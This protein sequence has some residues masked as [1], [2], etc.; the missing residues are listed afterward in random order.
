MKNINEMFNVNLAPT[1]VI[2]LTKKGFVGEIVLEMG[3]YPDGS[4]WGAMTAGGGRVPVS[5]MGLNI[6][7][8]NYTDLGYKVKAEKKAAAPVA[9]EP[10]PEPTPEP[11]KPQTREEALTAKYGDKAT[12]RAWAEKIREDAYSELTAEIKASGKFVSKP[13]FRRMLAEKIEAKKKA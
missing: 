7:Y 9:P 11:E 12:R 6:A 3:E 2:R 4:K 13:V 5:I 10:A 8:K 1:K